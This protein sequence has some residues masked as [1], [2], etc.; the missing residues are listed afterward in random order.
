M[1]G[2]GEDVALVKDEA[3]AGVSPTA[4]FGPRAKRDP[5]AVDRLY[6]LAAVVAR[7]ALDPLHERRCVFNRSDQSAEYDER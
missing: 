1:R 5:A 3:V 4:Q 2:R 7:N 6:A